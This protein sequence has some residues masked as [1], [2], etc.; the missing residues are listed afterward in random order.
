MTRVRIGIVHHGQ[1]VAQ[2][3][4]HGAMTLATVPQLRLA[5]RK[6]VAE[7][8]RLIILDLAEVTEADTAGLLALP[9][10]QRYCCDLE[11]PIPLLIQAPPE[12]PAAQLIQRHL[13]VRATLCAEI[14]PAA[15]IRL[16]P[17]APVPEARLTIWATPPMAARV[18]RFASRTCWSWLMPWMANRV[19]LVAAELTA[20]AVAHGAG[21]RTLLVT[22]RP[23]ILRVVVSDASRSIPHAVLSE[24][25]DVEHG[26]GVV[27]LVAE[28]W[29]TVLSGP[30]KE[31]WADIRLARIT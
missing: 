23:D 14:G 10:L 7:A 20:N 21:P 26:L 31:V 2:V 3:R 27:D 16:L 1:T 9:A 5:I 30:G 24:E 29:G 15:T 4:V 22:L 12:S 28:R 11:Y 8:P 13:H 6:C 18:H 17:V 25:P 19:Q